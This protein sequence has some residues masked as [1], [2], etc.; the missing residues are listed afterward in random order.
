MPKTDNSTVI[1]GAA[2]SN[3]YV[4][5]LNRKDSPTWKCHCHTM[6]VKRIATAPET[7]F[8]FWSAGEDGYVL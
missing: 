3:I 6:R 7:P 8:L 2:D 5:D 1:T 4:Y